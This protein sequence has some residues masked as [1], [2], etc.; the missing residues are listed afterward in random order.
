MRVTLS[1]GCNISH[2]ADCLRNYLLKI[3]QLSVPQRRL[4]RTSLII[5]FYAVKQDLNIRGFL[6]S[7]PCSSFG[8][9]MV[10]N[11]EGRGFP[12]QSLSLPLC[13]PDCFIFSIIVHDTSLQLFQPRGLISQILTFQLK[14]YVTLPIP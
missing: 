13:G 12:S 10:N 3:I 8:R 2:N 4:T 11:S 1:A 6:P 14:V 7:W 9:A 5:C